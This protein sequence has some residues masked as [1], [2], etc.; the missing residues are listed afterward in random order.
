LEKSSK[1][2]LKGY[3]KI[4]LFWLMVLPLKKRN[5]DVVKSLGLEVFQQW[6][7]WVSSKWWSY[8][9]SGKF[10]TLV[11]IFPT[12]LTFTKVSLKMEEKRT[13][14]WLIFILPDAT[15]QSFIFRGT[16]FSL[17]FFLKMLSDFWSKMK[18][19][20]MKPHVVNI[21]HCP[22]TLFDIPENSYFRFQL[23]HA[24]ESL[25]NL[26]ELTVK[27]INTTVLLFSVLKVFY[28]CISQLYL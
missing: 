13:I 15:Q 18:Q 25:L 1:S 12:V 19:K 3:K 21:F 9:C 7:N 14:F 26:K 24:K 27:F 10:Q 28:I 4:C 17:G 11:K 23:Q 2:S 8:F 5:V 16:F 20:F 22:K 6:K